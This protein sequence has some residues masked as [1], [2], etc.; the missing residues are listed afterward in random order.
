M[1]HINREAWLTAAVHLLEKE[2]SVPMPK[3]WKVSCGF[4]FGTRKA[5]GQC[6]MPTVSAA[7]VT[8]MFISPVLEVTVCRAGEQGV[9][10]VLLHEMIHASVGVEHGHKA[11]FVAVIRRCGLEGKPTAT[12]PGA[13]CAERLDTIRRQLGDY[14]GDVM[15]PSDLKK[16]SKGG[17]WPVF[18]SP[19]DPKYRVQISEKALEEYGP[20]ICPITR[21][22]MVRSQGRG[23]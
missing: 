7:G 17:Y 11:P 22:V 12:H 23:K 8:E 4:P 21:D 20:P 6:W 3:K 9:L 15:S 5:I 10:D 18:I 1:K 16:P 2:F 13:E 19:A 14:P